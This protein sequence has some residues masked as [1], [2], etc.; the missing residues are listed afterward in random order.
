MLPDPRDRADQHAEGLKRLHHH[1]NPS[2]QLPDLPGALV[3]DVQVHAGQER[4]MLAEPSGE[5]LGQFRDL[6]PQP[7]LGQL[8]QYGGVLLPI[9]QGLQHR[10]RGPGRRG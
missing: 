2:V 5:C 3:N 8:G 9:D 1:L 6:R 4:V 10:S 7:P